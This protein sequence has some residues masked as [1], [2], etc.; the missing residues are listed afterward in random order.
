MLEDV[1]CVLYCL[2]QYH[3][4]QHDLEEMHAGLT[5][6][7]PISALCFLLAHC[8]CP[9]EDGSMC[10]VGLVCDEYWTCVGGAGQSVIREMVQSLRAR[11]SLPQC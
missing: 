1:F 2:C 5:L 11:L 9:W 3:E 4:K 10:A 6:K 7:G 8:T